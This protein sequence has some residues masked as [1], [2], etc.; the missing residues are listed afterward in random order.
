[1]YMIKLINTRTN[2]LIAFAIRDDYR[3]A[4]EVRARYGMMNPLVIGVIVN[5]TQIGMEID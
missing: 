4:C 3:E 5:N 1:M 2:E